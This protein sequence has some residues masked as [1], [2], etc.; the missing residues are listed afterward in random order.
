MKNLKI[1]KESVKKLISAVLITTSLSNLTGCTFGSDK[2]ETTDNKESLQQV[3]VDNKIISVSDLRLKNKDNNQVIEDIDAV[4]IGN[5]LEREFDL[6]NIIFNSTVDSI[7][8]DDELIPVSKLKLVN[9]KTNQEIDMIDYALVGDELISMKDYVLNNYE[10]AEFNSI[11]TTEDGT[12]LEYE[13]LTDEKFFELADAVYKKYSEIGLDV[14]KEEVI[15]F[16]MMSNIEKIAKDNKELVDK[17]V[18]D[19]NT[20]TVILNMCDVHSAIKTKNDNNYCAKGLGFDSLIL[21]NDTVFDKETK[22]KVVAFEGRVKEIVEAA[23]NKENFNKLLN[24][25]LMEILNAN[26]DEFNMDYGSGYNCMEILMYFVRSNFVNIMDK[27]NAELI[28]YFCNYAE[29]YGTKYYE[30]SRSSAY[31]S[32]IYFLLTENVNCGKTLTK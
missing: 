14:S 30:N 24:T 28:R 18:G 29:D 31:Y 22:E 2:E 23:N 19:R 25:L 32:G 8:I 3:V 15:D 1:N 13:E 7:L 4:L 27:E 11:M 21:V 5:K 17:I 16:V 9:S 12:E 6:I 10:E 26:E 20:D